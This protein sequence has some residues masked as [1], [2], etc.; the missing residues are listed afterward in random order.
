MRFHFL[1]ALVVP[2]ILVSAVAI[3]GEAEKVSDPSTQAKC[4]Q[5]ISQTLKTLQPQQ[6]IRIIDPAPQVQ[7]HRSATN[8]FGKWLELRVHQTTRESSLLI[9]DSKNVKTMSWNSDCGP[10]ISTGEYVF[11]TTGDTSDRRLDDI[12]L[13][14]QIKKH[15]RGLLYL[16]EPGMVYSLKFINQFKEVARSM[17]LQFLP[18]VPAH[19]ALA[20]VEALLKNENFKGE[21]WRSKAIE[22]ELRISNLHF[23]QSYVWDNGILARQPILGVM[24]AK[25]LKN[26]MQIQLA[27]LGAQEN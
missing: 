3:G 24:S 15:K 11:N 5:S 16:F 1:Y 18:V 13:L 2:S 9:V 8:T 26:L 22:I 17:G 12:Q 25:T 27:R 4:H 21:I 6:W 14:A 7:A 20:S 10:H 23:P 19:I